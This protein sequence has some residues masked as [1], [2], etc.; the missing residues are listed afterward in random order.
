MQLVSEA[1]GVTIHPLVSIAIPTY[2]HADVVGAALLSALSQTYENIEILLFDNASSDSTRQVIADVA[3]GDPRVRYVRN[4][5]NL[6]MTGNFNACI[7]AAKG[8]FIKFLCADDLL[9]PDCVAKM[10]NTFIR[11][12]EVALVASAR[13]LVNEKL[14]PLAIAGVSKKEKLVDGAKAF[15]D[16]FFWGNL[17]GEPTAVMFRREQ[18][19]RGF[20][21]DYRQLIDLE[22]WMYLLR[23]GGLYFISRPLCTVRQHPQQATQQHLKSGVVLADKCRLFREFHSELLNPSVLEQLR[24]DIRMAATRHKTLQAGGS[25]ISAGIEE[26]YFPTM[27]SWF[28][29][30]VARLLL[31]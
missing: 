11:N 9:S 20:R 12:P 25:V 7:S 3:R 18:A 1:N 17:I 6:G 21:E 29:E 13:Q 27:F 30:P 26:T 5:V 24:W 19:V 4:E 15:R 23:S 2:N 10:V 14:M 8:Y 22:M 16:C 28:T 31:K